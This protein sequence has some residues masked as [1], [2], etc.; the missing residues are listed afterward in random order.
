MSALKKLTIRG[1]KS[2]EALED[3]ELR[4]LNVL[5]G[6]NG[7]GKSNLISFFRLAR[8]IVNERL[9]LFVNTH[10]ADGLFF[11]GPRVTRKISAKVEFDEMAYAFDLVPAVDRHV[12]LSDRG[13]PK[14]AELGTLGSISDGVRESDLRGLN[15]LFPGPFSH[16][17]EQIEGWHT[18]H[19]ND[20]N[21]LAPMRR[22]QSARDF[23]YLR[24]EAENIA[25][26]LLH[27]RAR[28]PGHYQMIR[29]TV[30][31]GAP[32]FDDFD[33]R[34]ET[35]GG[36]EHVR[37]EWRQRGSD[38]PFQPAHFSDGTIRFICL[39]T[40]LMQPNLPLMILIDEPELG[41]HPFA[42]SL[43]ADL[44]KSAATK[45]QIVVSTQSDRFVDEFAVEDVV[46]VRRQGAAS[47]FERLQPEP[48]ADW[49]RD[50][51][52]G[53]LWQ[54]NVVRAGPEHG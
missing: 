31:L 36:V 13:S 33:L 25:A 40:A 1:F 54:K 44:I 4:P 17:V 53:E 46:T 35:I 52:L 12:L 41:M 9:E 27:L 48:L 49:L 11:L 42:L 18:F 51:T 8:E 5:I 50:Y 32:F 29:D 6:A 21:L 28:H 34:P 2:I 19:F 24:S 39:V 16:I 15:A 7:A 26:V 38:F 20:T 10:G 43:L 23:S 47:V 3:F 22:T 14:G 30:R 45:A 37:L